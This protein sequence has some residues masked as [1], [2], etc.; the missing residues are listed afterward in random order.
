MV[1]Y[2]VVH[3]TYYSLCSVLSQPKRCS[4]TYSQAISGLAVA[5]PRQTK[6]KTKNIIVPS[7]FR[8]PPSRDPTKDESNASTMTIQQK[9]EETTKITPPEQAPVAVDEEIANEEVDNSIQELLQPLSV[10]TT[11]RLPMAS[12]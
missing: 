6:K 9:D 8:E 10:D 7:T 12:D 4:P 2:G 1:W 5:V 3:H 11:L